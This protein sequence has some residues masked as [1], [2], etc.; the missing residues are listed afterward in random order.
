[1]WSNFLAHQRKKN[2]N[3]ERPSALHMSGIFEVMNVKTIISL[4]SKIMLCYCGNKSSDE[5][6]NEKKLS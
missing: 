1:M 2:N 5:Y 3:K 4:W 6:Q